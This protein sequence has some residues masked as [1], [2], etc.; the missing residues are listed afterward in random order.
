MFE[1]KHTPDALTFA[2]V[3][4]FTAHPSAVD[5]D[6]LCRPVCP[7]PLKFNHCLWTF[8][9]SDRP[10]RMM[11]N[12][13]GAPSKD[14][15]DCAHVFGRTARQQQ[16]NWDNT[17]ICSDKN[18]IIIELRVAKMKH[19]IKKDPRSVTR[20]SQDSKRTTYVTMSTT[21]LTKKDNSPTMRSKSQ[22][23]PRCNTQENPNL[24][25]TMI[26]SRYIKPPTNEKWLYTSHVTPKPASRS[27]NQ[28][29]L[30]CPSACQPACQP[31]IQATT[32]Q[33][34]S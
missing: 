12:E 25:R 31:P 28:E 16:Q 14:F 1:H 5:R 24:N 33:P 6:S 26:C 27:I 21:N 23:E 32:Q 20:K 13:A 19:K 34:F 3:R 4:W 30:S 15:L 7:G 10:R 29:M 22:I 18:Q 11:V 8:A 9:T 17:T 2:L